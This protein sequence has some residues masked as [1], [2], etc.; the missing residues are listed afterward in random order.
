MLVNRAGRGD[1]IAFSQ[2]VERHYQRVSGVAAALVSNAA[3]AQDVTQAAFARACNVMASYRTAWEFY[4]GL[5][6]QV[7]L[8][9]FA[10]TKSGATRDIDTNGMG[11]RLAALPPM[12]RAALALRECA[13]F[14][15]HQIAHILQCRVHTVQHILARA[16]ATLAASVI[17]RE[18][19]DVCGRG[20]A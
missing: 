4:V 13:G 19:T 3:L 10:A 5:Y 14:T 15:Y 8:S 6:R 18:D 1:A 12:H 17:Y 16:R 2:L 7:L 9:C 11:E 20:G